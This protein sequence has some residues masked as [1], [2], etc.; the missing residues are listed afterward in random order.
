MVKKPLPKGT[1]NSKL[2]DLLYTDKCGLL[3]VHTRMGEVYFITF[4]DDF[5]RYG[6]IYLI[7]NKHEALNFF[8]IYALLKLRIKRVRKSNGFDLIEGRAHF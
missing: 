7:K 1:R 6:Y 8:Q 3:N 2:L 5:G 4:I